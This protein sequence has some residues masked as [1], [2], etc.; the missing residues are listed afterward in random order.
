MLD[1]NGNIRYYGAS[2][3]NYVEFNR[4]DE[5]WRIIGVFDVE[6]EDGNIEKRV[7]LIKD[8]SIGNYAYD[9]KTSGTGTS[10]SDYGSNDWSDAR[11]MMLLNPEEYTDSS[12]YDYTASLYWN[13][14]SGTCYAG[15]S[16]GTTSC[17]FTST[18]LTDVGKSMIGQA[19]YYLG[20]SSTYSGIYADD[21]YTF[22]RGTTVYSG[23][24]TSWIGYVGIMYPSDYMYATDLSVC[25]KV[26]YSSSVSSYDYRAT[27]CYDNDWLYN[28][29]YQW[30]IAPYSSDASN[31][32]DVYSDGFVGYYGTFNAI[33]VRPVV[34]LKADVIKISGDGTSDNPYQLSID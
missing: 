12:L 28:S 14:G 2:P 8:E 11:L 25:T 34:V 1:N 30:T 9:N 5:L 26:G 18:G 20:G 6:N 23:H 15:E 3:N 13:S 10:T 32:F 22:E 24:S 31:A 27:G 29:V 4:D 7:R 33:G 16:E 21:Y 19:K 17:D